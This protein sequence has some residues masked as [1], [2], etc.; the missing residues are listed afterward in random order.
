MEGG[1][2][3]RPGGWVGTGGAPV[4]GLPSGGVPAPTGTPFAPWVQ[5]VL[6]ELPLTPKAVPVKPTD[7]TTGLPLVF[8]SPAYTRTT[9]RYMLAMLVSK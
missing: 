8:A 7:S 3:D 4:G 6:F 2:F 1:G 5:S 9:T